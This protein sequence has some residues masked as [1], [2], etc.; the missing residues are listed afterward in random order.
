MLM[1]AESKTKTNSMKYKTE[2][3]KERNGCHFTLNNCQ[4]QTRVRLLCLSGVECFKKTYIS[5]SLLIILTS[6]N[7]F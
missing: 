2:K 7:F 1:K 5:C 6:F 4:Q 3:K